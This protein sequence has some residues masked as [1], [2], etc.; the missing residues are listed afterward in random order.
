MT[1][2]LA[3]I[4]SLAEARMILSFDVDI[5]D[6]KQPAR[7]A[8]GALDTEL[9]RDIVNYIAGRKPVSAT[10]GDL[11]LR[12]EIVS[13]VITSMAEAGVDFIKIGF[14]PG[15]D[16]LVCLPTLSHLAAELRLI[17]VLFA[18]CNPDFSIVP[19]LAQAGFSGVML[20]TM[21]KSQGSL[22]DLL[23]GSMM[24][25]FI[26]QAKHHHLLSGLAGSLK[27][28]DIPALLPLQTDY[29]G[30]RSALCYKHHRVAELDA[31]EISKLLRVF[32]HPSNLST[33]PALS[34]IAD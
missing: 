32:K 30:F 8:L 22:T 4:N 21:E 10:I 18:D 5:I 1:G 20:D 16:W 3:S 14:F 25:N 11:P 23:S 9:V 7:G 24:A 33:S 27:I 15:D 17:A 6:L 29:L 34:C 2:M 26:H 12:A 19:H 28:N 31:V 13:P